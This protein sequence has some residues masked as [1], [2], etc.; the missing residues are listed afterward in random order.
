MILYVRVTLCNE[1]TAMKRLY[2]W[3]SVLSAVLLAI[4]RNVWLIEER[5]SFIRIHFFVCLFAVYLF[6]FLT[7][8]LLLSL[9]VIYLSMVAYKFSVSV[10]VWLSM[11]TYGLILRHVSNDVTLN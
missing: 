6:V 9:C 8:C 1:L 7:A 5:D 10:F 4:R 11:S 3:A 2:T